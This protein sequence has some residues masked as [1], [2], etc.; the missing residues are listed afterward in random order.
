MQNISFRMLHTFHVLYRSP[1][2]YSFLDYT[3]QNHEFSLTTQPLAIKLSTIMKPRN[4][5]TMNHKTMKPWTQTK[6]KQ[7]YCRPYLTVCFIFMCT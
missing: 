7:K 2:M 4:K 6:H 1:I 3:P 5:N